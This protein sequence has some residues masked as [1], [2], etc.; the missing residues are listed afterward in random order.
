MPCPPYGGWAGGRTVLSNDDGRRGRSVPSTSVSSRP[1]GRGEGVVFMTPVIGFIVA[2]VAGSLVPQPKRA[3]QLVL[4]PWVTATA[5]QSWTIGAGVVGHSPPSTIR[6]PAYWLVQAIILGLSLGVARQAAVLRA[7]AGDTATGD[8]SRLVTLIGLAVTGVVAV[9]ATL[10]G[11]V[12]GTGHHSV[13]AGPPPFGIA[14]ILAL[15]V[16]LAACTV[17]LRRRQHGFSRA[18]VV[19][20]PTPSVTAAPN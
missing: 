13:H 8:R 12:A 3:M 14:F 19:E 4:L 2:L 6:S 17:V 5:V 18:S 20:V 7:S 1:S 11:R 15:A 16:T 9:P 10:I